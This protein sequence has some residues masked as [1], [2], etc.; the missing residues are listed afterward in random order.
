MGEVIDENDLDRH[1]R[2]HHAIS[3]AEWSSDDNLWTVHATRTDPSSG[4][5]EALT[6]TTNFL[7][8]CQG[9]YKH[10]QGY[11]PDWPG[12]DSYRGPDR[13]PADLADRHRSVRQAGRRDR[14]RRHGRHARAG[15]R[16]RVRARHDAAAIADLL[17]LAPNVNEVADMLRSLEIPEE[18]TH[19]IVRRKALQDQALITQLSFEEPEWLRAELLNARARRTARGLRR[20]HA[21]HAEVP[22]VA[23]AL[24]DGA[25]RRPVQGDQ[26]GQASVVTDE[27]DTF[28]ET[29]IL[30][31]SGEQLDADVIVTATGFDLSVLGDIAVHRRRRAGELRRH[32]HLPRDDVHRRAEPAVGVRLLPGEL[33]AACR[34]ARRLR[35]PS[36]APHGR[37]RSEQGDAAAAAGGRRHGTSARGSARTTSTPA[38]CSAACT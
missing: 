14:L 2:Y 34:P 25:R 4:T 15:D 24:G 9:Y 28:N 27:I 22:A 37:D 17:R 12:M 36:A 18:W 8:M 26:R 29:G 23:A 38:T 7:W 16:R 35:V 19:E 20:R 5:S 31:K 21:L 6:F 32:G 10:E 33:D 11:T 13:A 1:I 30:L 3:S